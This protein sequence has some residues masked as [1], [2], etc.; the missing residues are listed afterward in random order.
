MTGAGRLGLCRK[1]SVEHLQSIPYSTVQEKLPEGSQTHFR[2][3]VTD[4][5]CRVLGSN[6]SIYAIGDAATIQ[7]VQRLLPSGIPDTQK[8]HICSRQA[9]LVPKVTICSRQAF[10]VPKCDHV[11]RVE[12]DSLSSVFAKK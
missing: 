10:L 9:F 5:H 6:G 2:S 3:I 8:C 12:V 11:S 7:Q 4:Q 1:Y